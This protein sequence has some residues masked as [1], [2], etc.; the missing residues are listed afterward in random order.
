MYGP[1]KLIYP[2]HNYGIW[3]ITYYF[4][5]D[6]SIINIFNT[7]KLSHFP[8][9]VITL[10]ASVMPLRSSVTLYIVYMVLHARL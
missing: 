8:T 4:I 7:N 3:Q 2:Y 1:D 6:Y 10:L 5:T 9:I